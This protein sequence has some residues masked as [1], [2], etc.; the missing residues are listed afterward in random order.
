M[1]VLYVILLTHTFP[2]GGGRGKNLKTTLKTT[3]K[4]AKVKILKTEHSDEEA[5]CELL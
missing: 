4:V 3:T 2:L 5:A 1:C